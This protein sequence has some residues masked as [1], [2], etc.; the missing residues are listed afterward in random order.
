MVADGIS[1]PYHQ[2]I[3]TRATEQ[4]G[5]LQLARFIGSS[6]LDEER[7]QVKCLPSWFLVSN[8]FHGVMYD[9]KSR[10]LVHVYAKIFHQ[11]LVF[12]Q[13]NEP[14]E[15]GRA[16]PIPHSEGHL[17]PLPPAPAPPP[18]SL[19]PPPITTTATFALKQSLLGVT[20][21]LVPLQPIKAP[22]P[23]SGRFLF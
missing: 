17:L 6:L 4:G 14:E 9:W 3:L 22:L 12:K 1:V 2:P 21:I 16:R 19:P 15:L 13:C 11:S 20:L 18:S 5:Q 23:H 10:S 8:G 7:D